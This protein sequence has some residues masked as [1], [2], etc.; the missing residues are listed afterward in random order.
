MPRTLFFKAAGPIG[1]TDTSALPVKEIGPAVA[2]Y[3]QVLGF[4]LVERGEKTAKLRRDA[5]EIGLAVNGGDPEQASCWFSVGD[6]D[7]LWRELDSKLASPGIIDEQE[8]DGKRYR[9]FFAKEPYGVCFCFTHPL[10]S[11]PTD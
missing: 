8:F 1:D 11:A 2:Y 10:D 7:A 9:V 4:S 3:T 5:V 6:V